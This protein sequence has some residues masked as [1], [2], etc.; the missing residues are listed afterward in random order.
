M[1]AKNM[2]FL[3][4]C[5]IASISSNSLI[6]TPREKSQIIHE[7]AE[8]GKV[9]ETKDGSNIILSKA[10]NK[11]TLMSKMSSDG[12]FD[13]HRKELNIEYSTNA[14]IMESKTR[15]GEDGYTLYYQLNGKEYLTQ[16]KDEGQ[17]ISSTPFT[18]YS[19]IVSSF[20]LK[21]GMIFFAGIESKQEEFTSKRMDIKIY[22]PQ[23]ES[24]IDNSNYESGRTLNAQG[25]YI[26]CD[27]IKDNEVY[28]AFIHEES[29]LRSL[30]K[31]QHFKISEEG[32]ITS[33]S[34]PYL[35]KSFY[36]QFNALK[37]KKLSQNTIGIIFQIGNRK[38]SSSIPYGNT[39]KDLYFYQ[40]E[41]SPN[42]FEVTREDFIFNNCRYKSNPEDYTIDLVAI[43]EDLIYAM[44]EVDN[45]GKDAVA[46]RL[47]E[48]SGEDKEFKQIIL[49][50][51]EKAKAV[52]NP[53]FVKFDNLIAVLY[54]RI[55]TNDKKDVML[56][57][58]NYPDCQDSID[59]LKMFNV[60]PNKNQKNLL[61]SYFNIFLNNPYPSEMSSTPLYFR[62]TNTN[63]MTIQN[64]NTQLEL[65][66]DY[67]SSII[68][69]LSI[70]DFG[71]KNKT[72]I[73]YVV[74]RKQNNKVILGG[75][76]KINIEFPICYEKCEGCEGEGTDKDHKCFK[77][78]SG[79]YPVAVR[80]DTTGCGEKGKIYNCNECD[81]A[82]TEC[83]GPFDPKYPTTNCQYS[84]CNYKG[85]YYPFYKNETI[86]I[87]ERNKTYWEENL[88]CVLFLDE[89][90]KKWK[91]CHQNCSSCHK[92]PEPG[93]ENCDTCK[94]TET[95]QLFFY[96]NQ[97]QGNGIPGNCHPSCE[98]KGCYKSDPKD[99]EGME[100]MCPCFPNCKV[101][102]NN[103]TC[104]EC[105]REWLLPPEKT[106]CD[107]TCSYCLTKIFE[108]PNK[109]SGKCI[110]CAE[111]YDPPRYTF[112]GQCYEKDKIPKFK[113][114]E[115]KSE[116]ES[117]E[118]EKLYHVID[119]KCNLLTGCKKG[120]NQCKLET[121]KCTECEKGYYKEDIFYK[122]NKTYFKCFTKRQC[123]GNDTY[124]HIAG[125]REGGVAIVTE[126]E[127]LFCLNCR[128]NGSF[129]QPEENY[130]CGPK[131]NM[132]FVDIP[133]YNKLSKCYVRC[134][135][136][137]KY[138][139][140][141]EMNCLSCRD[142]KYYDLI[143]YDK[144]HGQCYRKQHK[145]G[146]YPYYHNYE[147]AIDED[148]CGED[149]DVCLYNFQCPKEF[150]F[151]KLETHECVEHCLITNV[152]EGGCSA[153]TTN[154]LYILLQNPFGLRYPYGFIN[155]TVYIHQIIGSNLFKYICGSYKDCDINTIT[156]YIGKGTV[157][158]LPQSYIYIGNN[159]SIELTSVKLELEKILKT[160]SGQ[161]L[162]QTVFTLPIFNE[163][164][165]GVE[166]GNGVNDEKEE[167]DGEGKKSDGGNDEEGK[168]DNEKSLGLNKIDE[169]NVT[170]PTT[171]LNLSECEAELKKIY[172]LPEEEDLMII[173]A[174]M[175]AEYNLSNFLG[176][177]TNYQIFSYSLGAFL[178]LSACKGENKSIEKTS[179]FSTP[180]SP[181]TSGDDPQ[182]TMGTFQSKIAS[183]LSNGYD[184][185]D[186]NSPFYN[187]ICTPFTNEQG[188]D[189]LLDERRKEYY[190][191]EINLCEKG[192]GFVEYNID[193]MTYKC[194]CNIKGTPGEELE[195][196]E[197]EYIEMKMPDDF[198]K[199]RTKLSNIA[200][201]KCASN[202]FSAKGQKNNYGSY[203]LL[204]GFTSF[205]GVLVFH[206]MKERSK[207]MNSL[208]NNLGRIANPPK[209]GE[210]DKNEDDKEKKSKK[211]SKGKKNENKKNKEKANYDDLMTDKNPS[212]H[213]IEKDI[214]YEDYEIN[215]APY[216]EAVSKDP[217]NFIQT[218]WSFIKFKQSI[219]FTFFTTSRGIL[220]S[221]KIAL[222][223][224][225]VAFYMA[226]TALFFND[227]IMR[228]I[229][230]YKGNTNAIIHIP[231]IVLSS[232]CS[233][234]ACLIVRFICLNEKDIY[235]IT[236]EKNIEERKDKIKLAKR[237]ASLKLY[238]FYALAA[239]ILFLCW[240]YV[241][242]FCAI[243]K[244]SQINYL[245]YFSICF[246][247]CNLWPFVT[248]II[249][250]IMRRQ[251]LVSYSET[252][253]KAS[254]IVSIF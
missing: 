71:N 141:C 119:Q 165:G 130:Y 196:Y 147:I 51:F 18:S 98:D 40:L 34:Q 136:C 187:D 145:C 44:C 231:N 107:K 124:P 42:K 239:I 230:K 66:K 65:N 217:R 214:T 129:R 195:D 16:F 56:L 174:D 5:L 198:K 104:E 139:V 158:N 24:K 132:T 226:F 120:C 112:N 73:E 111:Y 30:L 200:V 188:K 219:I 159:I 25:R 54:T 53:L 74:S 87:N 254:Q 59:N 108:K 175:L 215:F 155:E 113:Y 114:T 41:V 109:E 78:T 52:K 86:C 128:F 46:F 138:G 35:I 241:S 61:S 133:H 50:N 105:N 151:F 10:K 181:I 45:E 36:T 118:V 14:Q 168:L 202:V 88:K 64:G 201:F 33:E 55:D 75:K 225:F 245:I 177:E 161:E 199:L 238:I 190:N 60:C 7:N 203:I 197:G 6:F 20:T 192:C 163:E 170:I 68:S 166:S 140:P 233:F 32:Q 17:D 8:L 58:M 90:D 236:N 246:L 94:K 244:N 127:E 2:I 152:L 251:A 134:K 222:F 160:L 210:K 179:I 164:I 4:I 3:L 69:S 80:N 204:A 242:A 224:L 28:C 250:T 154:A 126:D 189:V 95:L 194:R 72:Y 153:A 243:F 97:T 76:C 92:L 237:K 148:D 81:Q 221:T 205:I 252:L 207:V 101:C 31:I 211:K 23:T 11:N 122:E 218:Y 27:E 135:T 15:R 47:I 193:A 169:G 93:N 183:V 162:K 234:I 185:F 240:Y 89:T 144:T 232:L 137:D 96:C 123:Q 100:K 13:Y 208:F 227:N 99:T 102:K 149:C 26:S 235:N 63:G 171:M 117:Y 229:Y 83:F 85:K 247:V 146:I 29:N 37:V 184:I 176:V 121:D 91:C 213:K 106:S 173:K 249:P 48:I 156:N 167:D 125:E 116:I 1:K 38:Y 110:N 43:S 186:A 67:S 22:D 209:D 131:I 84:K 62:L 57:R 21:N 39:G 253:Y 70:K 157:F 180:S 103:I 150:P 79:T 182:F 178:P 115:Y 143:R 77:C 82:C 49:N 206:F 172:K 216:G 9:C 12:T 19:S 212:I 223:I 142:S 228:E 248:S 220:R 191:E